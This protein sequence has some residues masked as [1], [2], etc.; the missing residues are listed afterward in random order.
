[1]TR[2]LAL[3]IFWLEPCDF[4]EACQHARPDF[5]TI[6][7]GKDNIGPASALKDAMGSGLSLDLPTRTK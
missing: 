7:K 2:G 6:M 5:F 3:Q 4:R 1:M